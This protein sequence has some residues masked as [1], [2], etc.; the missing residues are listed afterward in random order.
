V[1]RPL[2]VLSGGNS[3]G[4][5]QRA[6]TL[7]TG[8]LPACLT[9]EEIA[10]GVAEI[11][12]T[13]EAAGRE[14]PEDFDVAP[15]LG[16]AIGRTREEAVERFRSSQLYAHLASL[17]RSTLKD[18]GGELESR[19]LVGTPE[20][21]REQVEQYREAGATTLSGLLFA[22]NTVAE[23]EDAM[24]LFSAEVIHRVAATV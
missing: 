15:Q 11:R 10:G 5:K 13:A 4:S 9:P 22:A 6:A 16:V 20:Q 12:R 1:Q 8:W 21:V 24:A 2:P 17:S 18:Q 7:A 23:T 19:N 14:L 3:A